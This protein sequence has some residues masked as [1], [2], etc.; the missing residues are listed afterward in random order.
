MTEFI[1]ENPHPLEV[2]EERLPL[3]FFISTPEKINKDTQ[4]IVVLHGYGDYANSDYMKSLHSSLTT[5]YNVAIITVN[6]VGTFKKVSFANND[7][8]K[9][10]DFLNYSLELAQGENKST[11]LKILYSLLRND[12]NIIQLLNQKGATDINDFRPYQR[13]LQL[14]IEKINNDT[15]DGF[16]IID[17]LF[18]MGFKSGIASMVFS[19]EKDHQDFGVIQSIDVLTAIKHIKD[20]PNYT[21]L[22]WSKLSIVGTSHGA[23]VASMCDKLA[24][25]TF[26]TIV[27]N[28]GWLYHQDIALFPDTN[29]IHIFAGQLRYNATEDNYWSKDTASK[30][31]FSKNHAQI[32][33][34]N[35]NN[36]IKKQ[37]EQTLNKKTKQYIFSHTLNDEIIPIKQKDLYID[38]LKKIYNYITYLRVD[39]ETKLDGRTFKNLEHGASAS[40]KG[41][42]IDF[43]INSDF[44]EIIEKNDFDLK[45]IITYECVEDKYIINFSTTYPKIS[46]IYNQ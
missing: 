22:N 44:K 24:P 5:K 6:Y 26:N 9:P 42:T 4:P 3:S 12:T 2:E 30:N 17:R 33:A 25:N 34:L 10:Y 45:S 21:K 32:R 29:I 36:H 11:F 35:D 46:L 39:D 27:N 37:L 18:E 1:I 13:T 31:Y 41:L 15:C 14:L 7:T 43:I 20:N 16:Y 8:K 38:N 40:L 19:I 23:Y 28:A